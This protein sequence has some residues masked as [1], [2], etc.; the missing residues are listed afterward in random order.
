MSLTVDSVAKLTVALLKEAL[1]S[2]GLDTKGLKA[3]LVQRLQDALQAEQV[4]NTQPAPL[5]LGRR[6]NQTLLA[7][8]PR[9]T[10]S[11]R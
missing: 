10:P 5:K 1:T 9:P 7:F 3:A 6:L 2:R 8:N 11:P 4:R